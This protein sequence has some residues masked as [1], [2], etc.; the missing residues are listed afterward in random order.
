MIDSIV[1]D[2]VT[3]KAFA[4]V[5]RQ[6]APSMLWNTKS[7][8]RKGLS[9]LI[10]SE[11]GSGKS[12]FCSYV[13]GLRNDYTG[14]ISFLSNGTAVPVDS[15]AASV[16]LRQRAI[17]T[18]FQELRLFP[19]LS[20]LDNVMLKNRI[21][22]YMSQKEI[23]DML[24]RLGLGEYIHTLCGRMSLG[25]QQRV[26]FVRTLCQPADFI[27]LDEPV[28]HLD[29]TNAGIMAQ[30]L[31]ERVEKDNVGVIVTSIGYR[32]P[33]EYDFVVRL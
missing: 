15:A 26:A 1:F 7:V 9:Y 25:Q 17:A 11:S 30:M 33:Y 31:R 10:E 21:T 4:D 14:K 27:L 20:S 22:G 16:P 13:C 2:N 19:E 29:D 8:F 24:S 12:S 32:L 5:P 18:M 6:G 3:M 28:S 23:C